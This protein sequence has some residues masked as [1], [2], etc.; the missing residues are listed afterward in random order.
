MA[1][2]GPLFGMAEKRRLQALKEKR[3]IYKAK[4]QLIRDAL[5]N[6][7]A[8]NNRIKFEDDDGNNCDKQQSPKLQNKKN[9]LF[10]DDDNDNNETNLLWNEDEFSSNK[11]KHKKVTLGNDAR[12]TLDDRFLEDDH[13]SEKT[14]LVE[15]TNESDLQTEKEKQLDILQ[16]ILGK[17]FKTKC[18]EMKEETKPAKKGLMIRYDPTESKHGEYEVQPKNKSEK[19]E[20]KIKKR[21]L[22]KSEEIEEPTTVEVSKN[23]YY[24]VSNTLT[25]SLKQKEE[26]SLL[27]IYG[28]EKDNT[29][30]KK[31]YDTS[32][33]ENKDKIFKFHFNK[34]NA[35]KCD[36]SDE[37]DIN[38]APDTEKQMVEDSKNNHANSLSEY[39]DT[40]FLEKDDARFNEAEK[41]FSAE[42]TSDKF[43]NLR[44]ELKLIVRSKIRNNEK[45]TQQ[46]KKRKVKKFR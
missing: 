30:D 46:S 6:I 5:S 28:K 44:R 21:K 42:A 31:S 13:Q 1:A 25:E 39:K 10:S 33:V 45:K 7:N 2:L 19:K 15:N 3:Q 16:N 43:N 17:P 9:D 41:F 24:A 36:S 27:K 8:T 23:T 37:E 4:Q 14:E 40:L 20:K 26:F 29:E 38:T 35:F 34:N 11:D 12:F 32:I 22:D 18:L